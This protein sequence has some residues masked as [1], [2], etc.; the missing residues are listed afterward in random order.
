MAGLERQANENMLQPGGEQAEQVLRA[1]Y[2]PI[3]VEMRPNWRHDVAGQ[4]ECE[5]NDWDHLAPVQGLEDF[6]R[7]SEDLLHYNR[8]I[9]KLVEA[10]MSF[11]RS[12][13]GYEREA[14]NLFH[15]SLR[16]NREV[17]LN[18]LHL[19]RLRARF[20]GLKVSLLQFQQ[21]SKIAIGGL[22]YVA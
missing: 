15:H 10:G 4:E 12:R 22:P 13:D 18:N 6:R 21:E 20:V 8:A 5:L 11:A 14:Q 16:L 17:A 7:K 3:E 2:A 19:R 1:A 9:E